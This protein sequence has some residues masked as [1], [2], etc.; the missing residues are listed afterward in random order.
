MISKVG[1]DPYGTENKP[2]YGNTEVN[3]RT[4]QVGGGKLNHTFPPPAEAE[5]EEASDWPGWTEAAQ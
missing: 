4:G 3:L 5:D 1:Q 2:H